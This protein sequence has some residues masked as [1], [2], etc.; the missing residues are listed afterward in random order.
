MPPF[1]SVSRSAALLA[2]LLSL[3]PGVRAEVQTLSIVAPR[4]AEGGYFKMG[5]A[6]NPAGR[7][8]TVDSRSLRL[9]G[10]PWVPVMG[11]FHY[12]RYP[13]EEWR[14]ELLKMR[15]GGIDVVSTC[16]FWIH[17]EETEGV[18]DWSGSRDLRRFVETAR[19]VGL[20]V[21]VRCGPWGHGEVR[22]GG[23]P[24]WAVQRAGWKLRS[25]DPLFL[26]ATRKLYGQIADQLRG[27]LWKDGGPVI[28]IQLDNEFRGPADYLIALKGLAREAGLDVPLYMRTGWP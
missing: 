19:D 12:A 18:W 24:D 17:H 23:L 10:Q 22:N 15:A 5:T 8:L 14:E 2:F 27:L 9:D 16:V 7:E 21:V 28:G 6:R 25:T 20:K 26:S 13:A 3:M 1:P 11:E 4:P